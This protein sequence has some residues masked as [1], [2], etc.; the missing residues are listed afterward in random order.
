MVWW[1]TREKIHVHALG[2]FW[3]GFSNCNMY[4][5]LLYILNSDD[6]TFTTAFATISRSV[7]LRRSEY[8]SAPR[9]NL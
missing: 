6:Y 5:V 4:S 3:Q 7:R 2:R 1:D 8:V 9:D